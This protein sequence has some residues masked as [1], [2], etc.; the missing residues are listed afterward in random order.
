MT[1]KKIWKFINRYF[2]T[3]SLTS[4][5]DKEKKKKKHFYLMP[6]MLVILS[7]CLNHVDVVHVRG[8][9]WERPYRLC[10]AHWL[11]RICGETC[12]QSHNQFWNYYYFFS[13]QRRKP[14]FN[15]NRTIWNKFVFHWCHPSE[16]LHG[17]MNKFPMLHEIQW[18]L[19]LNF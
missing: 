7:S 10:S 19:E 6:L 9:Q 1:K 4:L 8:S 15:R 17:N 14:F 11:A 2:G 13:Q 16:I 12:L 5:R 3:A 18:D